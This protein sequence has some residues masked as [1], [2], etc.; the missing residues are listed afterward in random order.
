MIFTYFFTNNNLSTESLLEEFQF[1]ASWKVLSSIWQKKQQQS[2]CLAFC[3]RNENYCF[4]KNQKTPLQDVSTDKKQPNHTMVEETS[5]WLL[6]SKEQEIGIYQN[7][8]WFW[9]LWPSNFQCRDQGP[10]FF[11]KMT[12]PQV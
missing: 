12:T 4:A 2:H 9:T 7:Y 11:S 3:A 10:W 1:N 6:T 8:Y 5:Q